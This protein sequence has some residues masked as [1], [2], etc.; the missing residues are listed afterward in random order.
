MSALRELLI[1][2]WKAIHFENSKIHFS[3]PL[4]QRLDLVA[5]KELFELFENS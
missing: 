5:V 3:S 2:I 1:L 4:F